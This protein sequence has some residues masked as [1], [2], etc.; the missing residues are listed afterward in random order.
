MNVRRHVRRLVSRSFSGCFSTPSNQTSHTP[1]PK[2]SPKMPTPQISQIN[3]DAVENDVFHVKGKYKL[4]TPAEVNADLEEGEE[5]EINRQGEFT[6]I[7]CAASV[8][9]RARMW[10]RFCEVAVEKGLEDD[11]KLNTLEVVG[12]RL[13]LERVLRSRKQLDDGSFKY[14]RFSTLSSYEKHLIAT[15][16]KISNTTYLRLHI[17]TDQSIR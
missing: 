12:T 2:H 16:R 3:R 1:L 8:H 15:V 7:C 6:M 11:F 4:R 5:E 17:F 9:V 14:I 10:K 13:L